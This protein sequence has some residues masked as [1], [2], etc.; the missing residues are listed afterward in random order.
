[1]CRAT[2]V[3]QRSDVIVKLIELASK[4]QDCGNFFGSSAANICVLAWTNST[5]L[6]DKHKTAMVALV[7]ALAS[8]LIAPQRLPLTWKSV[9][10][11][12]SD[13][14]VCQFRHVLIVFALTTRLTVVATKWIGFVLQ[15]VCKIVR[16]SRTRCVWKQTKKKNKKIENR[17][18][19][20]ELL[21]C[22]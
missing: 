14:L 20:L 18:T 10:S 16:S 13:Q 22:I 1:M 6:I 2:D 5:E 4:L 19:Q 12:R 17:L 3:K 15:F 11:R 9:P 8:P 21:Y 7:H